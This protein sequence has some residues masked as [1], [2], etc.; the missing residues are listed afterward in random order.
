MAAEP[1]GRVNNLLQSRI[2]SKIRFK[3]FLAIFL[4]GFVSNGLVSV[5]G[6]PIKCVCASFFEDSAK[7]QSFLYLEWEVV[8]RQ[9]QLTQ[10]QSKALTSA[11]AR[12]KKRWNG[13]KASASLS[14]DPGPNKLIDKFFLT[15]FLQ[16]IGS[17]LSSFY[18]GAI[19][20][21]ISGVLRGILR[22][23]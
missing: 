5:S 2:F 9:Q 10:L 12:H 14:S 7:F 15:K 19:R 1:C 8:I 20:G 3:V 22:G 21:A 23:I 13:W 6:S 4:L 11:W 16:F 18:A 17:F